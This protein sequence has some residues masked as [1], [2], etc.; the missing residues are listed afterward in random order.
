MVILSR[1]QVLMEL[2]ALG[3]AVLVLD[4]VRRRRL[5]EEYSLLWL[6]SSAVI[7]VLGLWTQLLGWITR[8]CGFLYPASTVFAVGLGFL[9]AVL[10]YVSIRLSRLGAEK[11]ALVRELALLRYEVERLGGTPPRPLP[12]GER[13]GAAG[14]R[15]A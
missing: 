13:G 7:A 14:R 2:G 15:S 12:S 6:I 8:L 4:L 10:L 5:S 1:S 11:H 9:T 3:L